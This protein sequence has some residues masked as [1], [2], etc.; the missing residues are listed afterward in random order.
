MLTPTLPAMSDPVAIVDQDYDGHR[1]WSLAIELDWFCFHHRRS[2]ML[3]YL[4]EALGKFDLLVV[5][6]Q[7]FKKRRSGQ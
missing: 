2:H 7:G 5:D 1:H 6:C 4:N 3:A